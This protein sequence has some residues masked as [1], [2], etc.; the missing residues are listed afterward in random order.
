MYSRNARGVQRRYFFPTLTLG[1][2]PFVS[3]SKAVV[4][5]TWNSSAMSF[6][7]MLGRSS[8]GNVVDEIGMVVSRVM[9]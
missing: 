5:P 3:H 2:S 4:S 6:G 9:G 7:V 1:I 8:G